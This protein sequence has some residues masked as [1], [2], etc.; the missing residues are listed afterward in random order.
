MMI[1]DKLKKE[2]PVV[3]QILK[4]ALNSNRLSHAYLFTGQK[5]TPRMQAALWLAQSLVCEHTEE[6]M[7]CEQCVDCQRI[8]DHSY[9]DLMILDGSEKSIKKDDILQVQQMFNRTGLEHNG[10]KVYILDHVEN[11]TPEALNSLLKFLE[12][13][14]GSDILAILI[15]ENPDQ[16]LPTIVSRCQV[17]NFKPLTQKQIEKIAREDQLDE[18]DCYLL[19][20]MI[21]DVD[22]IKETAED[23]AYQNGMT[24]ARR[25]VQEFPYREEEVLIWIQTEYLGTKNK[26]LEKRTIKYFIDCLLQFYQDAAAGKTDGPKWMAEAIADLKKHPV[27]AET[28]IVTLLECRDKLSRP[29]HLP[30]LVDQLVIKMKEGII[31]D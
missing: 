20:H 16:I 3:Y 13:P 27:R 22:Q 29:Y 19:S 31:H 28:M 10:Q 18:T 5:G 1:R 26:D 12:E 14:Q 7:A 24:M 2:Q 9:A 25:F 30:L 17:L 15:A 21:R 6:G 23:E 8:A 11:S 4:N